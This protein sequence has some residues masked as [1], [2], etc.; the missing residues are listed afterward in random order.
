M[1]TGSK[2]VVFLPARVGEFLHLTSNTYQTVIIHS[3][4][5]ARYMVSI[6]SEIPLDPIVA[7]ALPALHSFGC[8]ARVKLA[9]IIPRLILLC[10]WHEFLKFDHTSNSVS[11][12]SY[13]KDPGTKRKRRTLPCSKLRTP[14]PICVIHNGP[15][16]FLPKNMSVRTLHSNIQS[17]ITQRSG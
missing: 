1:P 13:L 8:H 4:L 6:P 16:K 12:R 10:P 2:A 9:T 3:V 15:W 17:P 5:N 11:M 7:P 14:V